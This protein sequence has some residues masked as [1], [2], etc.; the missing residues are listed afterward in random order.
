M[1]KMLCT[2]AAMCSRYTAMHHRTAFDVELKISVS[3]AT[4]S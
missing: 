1:K 4:G 3:P 2:L